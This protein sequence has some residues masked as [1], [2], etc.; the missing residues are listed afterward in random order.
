M[1]LSDIKTTEWLL[2][3]WGRWAHINKG[4]SIS[5]PNIEPF[6]RLRAKPADDNAPPKAEISDDEAII[7]DMA[8]AQLCVARPKE[9]DALARYYLYNP[10]YRELGRKIGKHHKQVCDMVSGGKMWI[11]GRL[12][13]AF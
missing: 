12:I 1:N 4:V 13:S 6:E 2:I 8:V 9:G 3:N 11:E 5:Y 7:I 10:T